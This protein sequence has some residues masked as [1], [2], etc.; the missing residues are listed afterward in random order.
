MKREWWYLGPRM[1]DTRPNSELS[2]EERRDR[3][4]AKSAAKERKKSAR[5]AVRQRNIAVQERAQGAEGGSKR[6]RRTDGSGGEQADDP[7]RFRA[8]REA[9]RVVERILES[10]PATISGADAIRE[11]D[12]LLSKMTQ[13]TQT[14]E[15]M[16]N[17]A[18]LWGYT[19]VRTVTYCSV[20]LNPPPATHCPPPTAH[21]HKFVSRAM[22]CFD[23]LRRCRCREP[24]AGSVY[25][26]IWR[27]LGELG[28]GSRCLSVGG[29]PGTSVRTCI[30]AALNLQLG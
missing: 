5:E 13:G 14:R 11:A 2:P 25:E 9:C 12:V 30:G 10:R 22:L 8:Q 3:K 7:E 21:Q 23:A 4:E 24:T 28:G 16:A 26:D 6:R 17:G 1:A 18:A 29:G 20:S 15:Q 19:K 27:H